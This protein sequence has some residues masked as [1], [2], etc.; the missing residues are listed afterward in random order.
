MCDPSETEKKG[1]YH[2]NRLSRLNEFIYDKFLLHTLKSTKGQRACT[3]W[4]TSTHPCIRSG[5]S[6]SA[7]S[8][9][10]T[11]WPIGPI[12][13]ELLGSNL[14]SLLV[15]RRPS[16]I[17]QSGGRR[18]YVRSI[19]D[20]TTPSTNELVDDILRRDSVS[21]RSSLTRHRVTD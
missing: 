10:R 18:G 17:R 15:H 11:P 9:S 16:T 4:T 3:G 1:F 7:T 13:R 20:A 5:P 6:N 14:I 19:A 21:L 2:F 8:S 12:F